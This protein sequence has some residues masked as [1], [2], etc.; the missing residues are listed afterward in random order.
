MPVSAKRLAAARH[1]IAALL[2]IEFFV[3]T[4]ARRQLITGDPAT[5]IELARNI[6]SGAGYTIDGVSHTFYPPGFPLALTPVVAL[7]G[8]NVAAAQLYV[9]AWAAIALLLTYAYLE[10]R[11]DVPAVAITLY[12]IF[13]VGF[14]AVASAVVRSEPVYIAATVGLLLLLERPPGDR[15][16]TS[17]W[18]A[19]ATLVAISIPAIRTVG[20]A[21]AAAL[22]I[23][24]LHVAI[25]RSGARAPR[26]RTL[27]GLLAAA[28]GGSASVAAWQMWVRHHG[29]GYR[30]LF[31]LKDPLV[32]DEGIATMQDWAHRVL[33]DGAMLA[34][35]LAELVTNVWWEHAPSLV[36]VLLVLFP[37]IAR[38]WLLEFKRSV[39]VAAWYVLFYIA[40][41]LV[42]PFEEGTRYVVPILPLLAVFAVRGALESTRLLARALPS[43]RHA[44]RS[45]L[46]GL[47]ALGGA[48]GLIGASRIGHLAREDVIGT[49][50]NPA[51][52][53][54]GALPWIIAHT[55]PGDRI[56]TFNVAAI[57]FYTG[58]HTMD[59]PVT[60]D[61]F[62]MCRAFA[63]ARPDYLLV[64][65]AP[66]PY[67]PTQRERVALL[68]GMAPGALELVHAYSAGRIYR[69]GSALETWPCD[70]F[71]S[72]RAAAVPDP[73]AAH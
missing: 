63:A 59:F 15:V 62:R 16:P 20:V 41:L 30:T 11:G 17:G 67:R 69:V 73:T 54:R 14:Y 39:P 44:G 29:G 34:S 33:T 66:L 53:I 31:V 40:V 47:A 60:G 57:H 23:T 6:I 7:A 2:L 28:A 51:E 35:R 72:P 70:R 58:R 64:T 49:R 27:S 19:A 50:P 65:D 24:A 5:Y 48:Y 3:L 10:R 9:A 1:L 52:F 56:M 12:L 71:R 32:P 38:G 8:T 46:L 22:A 18:L 45:W 21:M 4:A 13:N 68:D 42:W 26:D 61:P 43:V 37:L 25:R 55:R 36:A